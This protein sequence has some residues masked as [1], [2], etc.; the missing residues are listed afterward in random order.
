MISVF[1]CSAWLGKT[2]AEFCTDLYSTSRTS[3]Q[4]DL[5]AWTARSVLHHQNERLG[6]S[7]VNPVKKCYILS[8]YFTHFCSQLPRI[9]CNFVIFT[10]RSLNGWMLLGQGSKNARRL[11][12]F[13]INS[14]TRRWDTM[15]PS[16]PPG[17]PYMQ[18]DEVL[19]SDQA[20]LS[21]R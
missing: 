1:R 3:R 21:F 16:P 6:A 7:L 18:T 2:R 9:K 19:T 12:L 13:K 4:F 17:Q 11:N 10:G 14:W 20:L 5:R 15:P 8:S